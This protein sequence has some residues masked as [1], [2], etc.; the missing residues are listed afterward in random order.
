LE[1]EGDSGSNPACVPIKTAL[2]ITRTTIDSLTAKFA[3][4]LV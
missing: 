2:D 4:L 3:E 1:S